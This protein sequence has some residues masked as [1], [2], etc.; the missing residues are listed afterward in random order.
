MQNY[1]ASVLRLRASQQQTQ[2][3][4]GPTNAPRERGN[5]TCPSIFF[6][7]WKSKLLGICPFACQN[8]DAS[9]SNNARSQKRAVLY[10]AMS[11]SL[12]WA[13]MWIPFY[14][15]LFVFRFNH[16]SRVL[17]GIF[18]PL[19]GLYNLIVYMSPKVRNAR[20]KK[21]AKLP[22]CQAITKA[23]MSKGEED[24]AILGC[25]DTNAS[26]MRQR[27]TASLRQRFEGR[28]SG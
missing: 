17:S 26:S 1:G 16:F 4:D 7:T 25:R 15:M 22:W 10:M 8:D 28:L 5:Q 20:N 9:R 21:R 3:V 6:E 19:Q 11:Y 23:W 2:L 14:M 13:L 24:R 12:T 18:Q 27:L